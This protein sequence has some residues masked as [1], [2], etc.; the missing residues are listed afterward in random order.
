MQR[1]DLGVLPVR[2]IAIYARDILVL[3]DLSS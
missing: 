1:E 3:S 2:D